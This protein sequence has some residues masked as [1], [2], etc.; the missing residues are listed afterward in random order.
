MSQTDFKADASREAFCELVMKLY[1]NLGGTM[2]SQYNPF[3]DTNN[4]AVIN[5]Y[6]AGIIGGTSLT[7]FSPNASITR[8]QLCV[9]ILKALKAADIS[10]N[11][12]GS[13]QMAYTDLDSI[14]NWATESVRTLNSYGIINGSGDSLNPLGTV[15]KEMAVI[16][17][18]KAYDVFQ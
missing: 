11:T 4:A 10:V 17:I 6:N 2:D 13:Y 8:E 16:M 14:T 9:M 5:A 7:T 15:S 18:Y 12:Q 1:E 3:T